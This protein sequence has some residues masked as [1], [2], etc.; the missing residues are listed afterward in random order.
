RLK[1]LAAPGCDVGAVVKA[2]AYGLGMAP[3]AQALLNAGCATF[4]VA[5]LNEAVA[6]RA[7]LGAKPR[8][9]AMHGPTAGRTEPGFAAHNIVPVL[10]TPEQIKA[11]RSFASRNDV[12]MDCFIQID[13]GMQ[14]LGL[15]PAEFDAHMQ[16][17]DSFVGLHPQ[18]LMSHLACA[19]T[20][21]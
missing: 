19:D 7:A 2:D 3:V 12:L 17:S 5:F 16:E 4:Y 10:S 21:T 14:R 20:P 18:A 15:T 11:W 13:T 1:K 8:I 9:I 6:L